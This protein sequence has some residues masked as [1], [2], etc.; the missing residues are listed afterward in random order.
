MFNEFD[1]VHVKNK[2]V[3]GTIVDIY[4]RDGKRIYVVEDDNWTENNSFGGGEYKLYD[5]ME[6]ELESVKQS[7][8]KL[9][10][11]VAAF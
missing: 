4:E 1:K 7:K 6:S 9:S 3:T 5:C 11:M 2:S 10:K 8:H